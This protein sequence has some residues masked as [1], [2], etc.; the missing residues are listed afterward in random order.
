MKYFIYFIVIIAFLDTFSQLPIMS[1]YAQSLGGTPLIIGL[2]I[3]MYSFANMIGNIIAGISVDKFGAK[4]VL[5]TS[6]GITS[7]IVLLYTIVQNGEQLLVVRFLHGFSDGFLIPAAFTFLSKQTKSTKQGKAMALSGAAVGTAAI[8]GPAFSG[9]M[10]ATAGIQWVFITI[11]TLMMI[12]TIVSLFLLPSHITRTDTSRTQMMTKED[13]MALVKSEPLL[14]A[15]IGAFTLMFSQG[16]VTYMLPMKVEAL[17]LKSSTTGMM[18]SI[19][20]ITAILFFLLPTNRIFDRFNRSKMMLIGITVM[21]LSL[22]LLGLFTTKGMIFIVM[23]IYGVGFAILFPSINALLVENT[24]ENN[25]GK[26]FGLFYAFFSLGVVAGS[27]TI[28]AIGAS[29][30]VSFII[31]TAFLLTFAGMIYVRGKVKKTMLG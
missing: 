15:Y 3:G 24:T 13:M 7:F 5:Y 11:S 21:A 4:K 14:Q 6:M 20:G 28:G 17:A 30:S 1:T 19:F 26:A 10:K 18:M 9:I 25:R 27:F 29:P 2:V 8:V 31:G 22:S 23:M 12:G 16:I